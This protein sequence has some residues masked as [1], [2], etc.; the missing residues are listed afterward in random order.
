[1]GKNTLPDEGF[2]T[3]GSIIL[4][5]K[6]RRTVDSFTTA[7]HDEGISL[8]GEFLLTVI[9]DGC[10]AFEEIHYNEKKQGEEYDVQA[11]D[12]RNRH[13]RRVFVSSSQYGLA[14]GF[15]GCRRLCR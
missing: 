10:I 6:R 8:G 3:S 7:V 4:S 13:G 12:P 15:Y 5:D 1:M 11:A 14:G 9:V 2:T